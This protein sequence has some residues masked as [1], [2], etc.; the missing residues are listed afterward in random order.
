MAAFE[1]REVAQQDVAAVLERDR[2]VADAGLFGYIDRVVAASVP[3]CAEAE[4][5]A[6][7]QPGAGDAEVVDVFAPE[8]GVVPVIV[9]VVLVGVPWGVGLGC[10]VGSAV[11]AGLFAGEWRVGGDDGA[12]LQQEQMNEALEMNGEAEVVSGGKDD[13]SATSGGGRFDGVV[14]GVGVEGLAVSGCAVLADVEV[15]GRGGSGVLREGVDE[16]KL[17]MAAAA[18]AGSANVEGSRAEAS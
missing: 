8:Q 7:D 6:I 14:D 10:V 18:K 3:V 17:G 9:A 2:L 11:I 16:E 4:P 1:N 12:A 5:F 15:A 13:D